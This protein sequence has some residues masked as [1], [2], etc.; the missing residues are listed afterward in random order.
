MR[1]VSPDEP[2]GGR[3]G[4]G[5][6]RGTASPSA[7]GSELTSMPVSGASCAIGMSMGFPPGKTGKLKPARYDR[8]TGE[9]TKMSEKP[10]LD[11]TRLQKI[12]QACCESAR[13][14]AACG[15]G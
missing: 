6:R 15:L 9:E 14:T 8:A 5:G 4:G 13:R 11:T 3:A 7:G 12:P 10:R 2:P 1:P